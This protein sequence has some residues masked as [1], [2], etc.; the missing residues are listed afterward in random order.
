MYLHQLQMYGRV[1]T[2]AVDVSVCTYTRCTC[3]SVYLHCLQ[4]Y[5]HVLTLAVDVRCVL[6]L[7]INVLVCTYTSCRCVTL[8]LHYLQM[9]ECVVTL[10][11]DVSVCTYTIY[12]CISVYLHQWQ[13]CEIVLTRNVDV[14]VCTY[15]SCRCVRLYLR[16]MQMYECVLTLSVDVLVCAYSHCEILFVH[17]FVGLCRTAEIFGASEMVLSSLKILEDANFLSTS[18]TAHQW[19]PMKQV[20]YSGCLR[21]ILFQLAV[22]CSL[23]LSAYLYLIRVYLLQ[24]LYLQLAKVSKLLFVCT[25]TFSYCINQWLYIVTLG[26]SVQYL[27]YCSEC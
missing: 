7:S 14:R 6:T 18:V 10:S 21:Y 8:Y 24:A 4:M 17:F 1:L 12:R 26:S 15:T 9:Y 27:E 2:L 22:I 25:F 20:T 3:T 5:G 11:I 23:N 19:L 16:E 13:M